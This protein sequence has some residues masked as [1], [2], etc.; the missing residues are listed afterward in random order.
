MCSCSL[1]SPQVHSHPCWLWPLLTQLFSLE[2]L[3]QLLPPRVVLW[4]KGCMNSSQLRP[5]EDNANSKNLQGQGKTL[6]LEFLYVLR[7]RKHS[8]FHLYYEVQP[9]LRSITDLGRRKKSPLRYRISVVLDASVPRMYKSLWDR[10]QAL[11]TSICYFLFSCWYR[12]VWE[13]SHN[14]VS[15]SANEEWKGASYMGAVLQ[16]TSSNE[17]KCATC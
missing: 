17:F 5:H 7:D 12:V 11:L 14:A 4:W 8:I 16:K 13:Q 15:I 6:G 3:C 9:P 2:L 10:D 1:Q